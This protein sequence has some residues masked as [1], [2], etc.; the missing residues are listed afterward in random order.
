MDLEQQLAP[1]PSRFRAAW[2]L[3]MA[4]LMMSAALPWIGEFMAV[5]AAKL[6]RAKLRL[7][8]LGR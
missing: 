6:R 5:R 7:F 2:T 3:S 8:R 4:S 1:E